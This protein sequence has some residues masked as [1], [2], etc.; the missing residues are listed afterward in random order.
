MTGSWWSAKVR[1]PLLILLVAFVASAVFTI[2]SPITPPAEAKGVVKTKP[3]EES[4]AE[5]SEAKQDEGS[6]QKSAPE[7]EPSRPPPSPTTR[8]QK[9]SP[10]RDTNVLERREERREAAPSESTGPSPSRRGKGTPDVFGQ[11]RKRDE[12]RDPEY[13]FRRHYIDRFFYPYDDVCHSCY[14][15]YDVGTVIIIHQDTWD[16]SRRRWKRPY[17][18]IDPPLGSLEEALVDIEGTWWEED[19]EFLMWHIDPASNV[20][21]YYKGRYSHSLS[22]REIFKL[23]VEGLNRI[24]TTEFRFTSVTKHGFRARAKAIHK[25]TGPDG[26]RRTAYLIYVLE[27]VRERWAVKRVDFSK[28]D[29][30]SPTCFIATAAYGTP[31]QEEVL[32][33]REFRDRYLMRSVLGRKL[34]ALYYNVSPPIAERNSP[35]RRST[36]DCSHN[37][38]AGGSGMQG[39]GVRLMQR[40]GRFSG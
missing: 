36:S 16:D 37:A 22:P 5:K 29:Y 1:W 4:S 12:R 38:L 25:F 13:K 11:I 6:E 18:Y 21:I 2:D 28:T 8:E 17:D 19:P 30:G 35:K 33:L 31:M 23:T 32:V 20:E 26:K 40:R 9:S 24:D 27:K 34:V 39:T 14:P 15:Y 7:K 10:R 3:K